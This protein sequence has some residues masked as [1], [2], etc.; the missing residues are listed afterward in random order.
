MHDRDVPIR[1]VAV[2]SACIVLA[3]LLVCVAGV[4]LQ[5]QEKD[6]CR[7]WPWV[8]QGLFVAELRSLG[9]ELSRAETD[10]AVLRA[11]ATAM[12]RYG[13]D[14]PIER[15]EKPRGRSQLGHGY[16]LDCGQAPHAGIQIMN[17]NVKTV[18]GKPTG[19]L[20]VMDEGIVMPR[21]VATIATISRS[22]VSFGVPEGCDLT[23]CK[24]LLSRADGRLFVFDYASAA[25][26][27]VLPVGVNF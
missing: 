16:V 6:R 17:P 18:A 9:A 7:E 21:G 5:V 24:I 10:D 8:D 23:E 2:A 14:F 27:R 4:T 22:G 12:M 19:K 13:I 15:P 3:V 25:P 26:I 1:R 11:W 20:E